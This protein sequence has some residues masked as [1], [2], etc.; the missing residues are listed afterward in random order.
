MRIFNGKK[1]AEKILLDLKKRIKEK[2]INPKLAVILVGEDGASKL[3]IKLKKIAAREIGIKLFLYKFGEKTEKEK[4]VRKIRH[5]NSAPLVNGII[6]QL[7]LP[8]KFNPNEIVA[9]ISSGKDVDGFQKKSCFSPVLPSAV[10]VALRYG[11][12]C[13]NKKILALVNSEIFG[14]TLK[15]FLGKKGIKINYILKKESSPLELKNK[16]K[17]ADVVITVCGCPNFIKS[18]MI[19]KRAIL[20]DA[21]ATLGFKKVVG[22]VDRESV[23][24]KAGFLAPV[25]G[26]IGP[27]TVA[28]LLKNVYLAAAK[29]PQKHI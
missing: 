3:Y 23:E 25:P 29:Y 22:D 19:K 11:A 26:G 14:R 16:L 13:L 28:L 6:V 9:E 21:G 27:L 24:K 20:I 5:L 15:S 1:A 10:L 2:G 8:E 18:D 17:S 4:I 7:P 12:E